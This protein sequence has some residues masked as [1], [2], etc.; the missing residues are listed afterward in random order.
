[1]SDLPPNKKPD[2]LEEW[3]NPSP[4]KWPNRIRLAMLPF[5]GAIIYSMVRQKLQSL[6]PFIAK[7][8]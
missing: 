1:M 2:P 5:I 8:Q 6:F 7:L 3:R 4:S